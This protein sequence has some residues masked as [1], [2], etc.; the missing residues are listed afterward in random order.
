[1]EKKKNDIV[2]PLTKEELLL[3]PPANMT[4]VKRYYD[5]FLENRMLFSK[6][7]QWQIKCG[8]NLIIYSDLLGMSIWRFNRTI[9]ILNVLHVSNQKIKR[10]NVRLPLSLI[11]TIPYIFEAYSIKPN[12][13]GV[14]YFIRKDN[15]SK[16]I[17]TYHVDGSLFNKYETDWNISSMEK[18][19][20]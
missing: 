14:G 5:P 6:K 10:K 20:L 4:W 18:L 15:L 13:L 17:E 3:T 19:T 1:M 12:D 7:I 2:L 16:L 8:Y 9:E 11:W